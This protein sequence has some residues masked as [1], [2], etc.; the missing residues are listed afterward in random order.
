M[1][2]LS[3]LAILQWSSRYATANGQTTQAVCTPAHSWMSNSKGQSPC[4]VAAY[5][6]LTCAKGSNTNVGAMRNPAQFYTAKDDE[7]QCNMVSYALF[8]ACQACQFDN[9]TAVTSYSRY[10]LN[11][12]TENIGYP[13]S[14]PVGTAVPA[15]AYQD[16]TATDFFNLSAAFIVA[17]QKP[18]DKTAS[19]PAASSASTVTSAS[20]AAATTTVDSSPTGTSA[21]PSSPPRPSAAQHKR[22]VAVASVVGGVL[23]GVSAFIFLGGMVVLC[24]HRRRNSKRPVRLTRRQTVELVSPVY[25]YPVGKGVY[26]PWHSGQPVAGV[27]HD[28]RTYSTVVPAPTQGRPVSLRAPMPFV[29]PPQQAALAFDK[30]PVAAALHL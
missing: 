4:L 15:W 19:I 25:P 17:A 21:A 7:C 13:E 20:V 28:P 10:S 16:S 26:R 1:F 8:E 22:R 29:Q 24:L 6:H 27:V 11:C 23:G 30:G 3:V 14:I 9:G 18:P 12:T 2:A 5:L